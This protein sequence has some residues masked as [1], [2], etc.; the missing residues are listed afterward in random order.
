MNYV[1]D[2]GVESAMSDGLG[3]S[4]M[5]TNGSDFV[6]MLRHDEDNQVA[7]FPCSFSPGYLTC[8]H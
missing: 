7:P 2:V 5:C 8:K 1:S 6:L 4:P 3:L